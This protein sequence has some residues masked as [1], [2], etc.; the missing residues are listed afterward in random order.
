MTFKP[1]IL[2]YRFWRILV[3]IYLILMLQSVILIIPFISFADTDQ[4]ALKLFLNRYAQIL[5]ISL[6]GGFLLGIAVLLS[7]VVSLFSL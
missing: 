4:E 3:W 6:F 2:A 7:S 5:V 1:N